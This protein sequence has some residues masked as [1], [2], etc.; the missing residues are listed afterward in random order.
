VA[1]V[2]DAMR[3][4]LPLRRHGTEYIEVS[5]RDGH[6][7]LDGHVATSG[8]RSIASELAAREPGVLWIRNRLITDNEMASAVAMAFTAHA[9]LQPSLV[10]VD[11][12]LGTVR[13][14][15]VLATKAL[16]DLAGSVARRTPG[17][18]RVESHLAP[19]PTL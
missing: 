17:V 18:L 8:F 7:S 9:A 4:F 14:E 13:L 2:R 6:V 11:A 15:G 1:D 3:E 16:V 10:R 12:R 19:H 5:A